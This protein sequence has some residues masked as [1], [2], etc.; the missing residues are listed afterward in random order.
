MDSESLLVLDNDLNKVA[1][2]LRAL[3]VDTAYFSNQV[4][5]NQ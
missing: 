5:I 2:W 4:I 3:G 1:R